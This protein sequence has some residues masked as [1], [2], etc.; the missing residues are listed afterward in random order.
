MAAARRN[1]A[2]NYPFFTPKSPPKIRSAPR[3]SG[4]ACAFFRGFPFIWTL[5]PSDRFLSLS[6]L[7]D[8]EVTFLKFTNKVFITIVILLYRREIMPQAIAEL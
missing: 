2:H 1:L 4:L 6:Q 5:F 8:N 7:P 3:R